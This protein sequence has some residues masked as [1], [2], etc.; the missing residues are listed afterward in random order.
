MTKVFVHGN[1]ETSVIWGDLVAELA[2]RGIDDVVLLSP[3]AF[4]APIP[5]GFELTYRSYRA[6]LIGELER[7]VAGSGS[8]VD[9]VGHDWGAGHTF[10]VIADR[11]DLLRTW[12]ADVVGMLHPDYVWHDA[13]Q[14]WMVEGVGEDFIGALVA[15]DADSLGG[16]LGVSADLAVPLAA[17]IDADMGRAILG[18]YRSAP[19][20][21]LQA[22]FIDM[23]AADRRPGLALVAQ[24]DQYVSADLSGYVIGQLGA[25]LADLGDVGHWWMIEEPAGAADVLT[26][27]WARH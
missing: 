13:A 9:L 6:W 2:D 3:P 10:G 25:D 16:V 19:E 14:I 8:P 27:F 5:D 4:G 22:M 17:A 7:I 21:E 11:P 24:G 26:E 12:A 23:L 20:P 1:P 15:L 18:L